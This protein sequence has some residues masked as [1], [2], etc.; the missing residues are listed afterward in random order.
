LSETVTSIV[1]V[2]AADNADG[3]AEFPRQETRLETG[4]LQ[5]ASFNGA[6]FRCIVT[7]AVGVIRRFNDGP[8]RMLGDAAIKVINKITRADVHDAQAL[9]TRAAALKIEF[10]IPIAADFA[11]LAFK[12]SGDI[13]D[14]DQMK[15]GRKDEWCLPAV[16]PR[17]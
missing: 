1:G 3:F 4:A 8:E 16:V 14:I 5:N 13:E 11:A 10:R 2:E 9:V 17:T 12:A 6:N 7:D 15:N